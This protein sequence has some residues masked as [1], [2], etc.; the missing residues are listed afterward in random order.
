[1]TSPVRAV[2]IN[3]FGQSGGVLAQSTLALI[4]GA[5]I[6]LVW[7]WLAGMRLLGARPSAATSLIVSASAF[8]APGVS[9]VLAGWEATTGAAGGTAIG[10]ALFASWRSYLTGLAANP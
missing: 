8:V 6:G 2:L 3:P 1:L 10:F 7:G 5:G 9:F 4:G